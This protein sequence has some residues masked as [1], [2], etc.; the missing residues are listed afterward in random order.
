MT[1][2]WLELY[3]EKVMALGQSLMPFG[4]NETAWPILCADV[5]IPTLRNSGY[6]I[7]GGDIY[8]HEA[9]TFTPAYENWFC[10]IN[11]GEQWDTF[12]Q[13]SCSEA[14]EYLLGHHLKSDWWFTLVVTSKPDA[15]QLATSYAR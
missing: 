15:A 11:V 13:R 2:A 5:L 3:P 6:A 7:L 1:E 9:S 8:V 10:S 4:V 12:A 14:S